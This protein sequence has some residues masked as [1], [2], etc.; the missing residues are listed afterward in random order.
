MIY[1]AFD[2]DNANGMP[3]GYEAFMAFPRTTANVIEY[4]LAGD[5]IG[6]VTYD[7]PNIA[8]VINEIVS[9]PGWVMGNSITL[10]VDGTYSQNSCGWEF[11]FP[12]VGGELGPS[13]IVS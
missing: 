8:A 2:A 13:L 6:G 11:H 1:T 7:S 3:Y 9:R 12:G 4:A 10:V 5:K